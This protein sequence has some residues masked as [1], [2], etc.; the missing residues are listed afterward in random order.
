MKGKKALLI[1]SFF[2]LPLP[3]YFPVLTGK[4]FLWDDARELFY[5]QRNFVAVSMRHGELPLW[6]PYL[7][8]GY[9]FL[10]DIQTALFYPVT[11]LLTLFVRDGKL[12]PI[13][14]EYTVVFHISLAGIFMFLFLF[15][16]TRKT[17]PSYLGAVSFMFTSQLI[18][19][20]VQPVVMN[21]MVYLPLYF[22]FLLRSIREGKPLFA[23]A[24]GIIWGISVLAGYP[25]FPMMAILFLLAFALYHGR[26]YGWKRVVFLWGIF[27]VVGAGISAIQVLPTYEF[28]LYTTRAAWNYEAACENSLRPVRFLTLFMPHYFGKVTGQG[29]RILIPGEGYWTYWEKGM[30]SGILTLLLALLSLGRWKKERY[31]RFFGV[32][33]PVLAWIGMGKYGGIYYLLYLVPFLHR[34]RGP[35]K[36][37]FFFA[38]SLSVLAALGVDGG[39]KKKKTGW[40]VFAGVLFLITLP[41]SPAGGVPPFIFLIFAVISWLLV[42]R[43]LKFLF[44][45]FLLFDLFYSSWGSFDDRVNWYTY[46]SPTPALRYF[47]SKEGIFRVNGRRKGIL[48]YPRNAGCFYPVF[49]LQGLTPLRLLRFLEAKKSMPESVYLDVYNVKYY[50][51]ESGNL[52]ENPDPL[53]RAKMFYRWKV[54]KNPS[55][56]DVASI[57]Y[58]TT[59]ILEEDPGIKSEGEG[60]SRVKFLKYEKNEIELE[61]YTEKPGVLFLSEHY[62][63]SWKVWVDGNEG[64]IIPAHYSFR[65]IPLTPGKHKV[66]LRFYSP[67]FILGR[68]VTFL[69]L[70]ISLAYIT[71]SVRRRFRAA[72]TS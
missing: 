51:D 62:Y 65:G 57:D 7:L 35:S 56:Q 58:R 23:C 44:I 18:L 53:P 26:D 61:V 28:S 67:P 47:L 49:T 66:I 68:M 17:F 34:F 20:S 70:L 50:V 13:A 5:P 12:S 11:W 52:R 1:L 64:R 24:G 37:M 30:Y 22:Y 21:S 15:Y 36:Y 72:P 40:L 71:F 2:L 63:P 42:E 9:P 27:M 10:H 6:Q 48:L 3:L 41:F 45:P 54:M 14:A 31:V 60:E 39:G 33:L 43:K 38:F 29:G 25:Q 46:Y 19:R 59:L 69:T 16:L 4:T 32:S 8:G 55:P